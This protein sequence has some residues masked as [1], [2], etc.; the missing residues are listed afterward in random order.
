MSSVK[1]DSGGRRKKEVTAQLTS[2]LSHVQYYID[3]CRQLPNSN[4]KFHTL[5]ALVL[6]KE[7]TT[8]AQ[9]VE[10]AVC[11]HL[12]ETDRI[13]LERFVQKMNGD[14]EW[15]RNVVHLQKLVLETVR[16]KLDLAARDAEPSC[17]PS[18][19]DDLSKLQQGEGALLPD[20]AQ[21]AA[22][23]SVEADTAAPV[24]PAM[25]TILQRGV[26]ADSSMKL[27]PNTSG[28]AA[29]QTRLNLGGQQN[30]LN[31]EINLA[32]ALQQPGALPAQ[33]KDFSSAA[34]GEN[35]S[36][37]A[38]L[39]PAWLGGGGQNEKEN[40][41]SELSSVAPN[42]G[43]SQQILQRMQQEAAASQ[44]P[45]VN[46]GMPAPPGHL[47]PPNLFMSM[48]AAQQQQMK[49]QQGSSAASEVASAVGGAASAV[50]AMTA[51]SFVRGPAP[52]RFPK[53]VPDG[54]FT[55]EQQGEQDQN[56]AG[57]EQFEVPPTVPVMNAGIL[58]NGVAATEDASGVVPPT[59]FLNQSPQKH[60]T[61]GDQTFLS[62]T[63]SKQPLLPPLDPNAFS[64]LQEPK[65]ESAQSMEDMMASVMTKM[66]QPFEFKARSELTVKPLNP[67]EPMKIKAKPM[68]KSDGLQQ[69]MLESIKRFNSV[70]SQLPPRQYVT[71]D[72]QP[73]KF[74]NVDPLQKNFAPLSVGQVGV[75]FGGTG[76]ASGSSQVSR[77]GTNAMPGPL[78]GRSTEVPVW[79]NGQPVPVAQVP[80]S[81]DLLEKVARVEPNVEYYSTT[82]GRWIPAVCLGENTDGTLRLDVKM[83]A[84]P[85][86][87][88][89][90][91]QENSG[92]E[93]DCAVP[94]GPSFAAVP[95]LNQPARGQTHGSTSAPGTQ[96]VLTQP[97]LAAYSASILNCGHAGGLGG[98]PSSVVDEHQMNMRTGPAYIPLMAPPSQ[99]AAPGHD[100]RR[101]H[102]GQGI[103]DIGAPLLGG[104][105][106]CDRAEEPAPRGVR[107]NQKTSVYSAGV[108]DSC[109]SL[110][111]EMSA[112]EEAQGINMENFPEGDP[113]H[114][115]LDTETKQILEMHKLG[116]RYRAFSERISMTLNNSTLSAE[117]QQRGSSRKSMDPSQNESTGGNVRPVNCP[118]FMET[119][120]ELHGMLVRLLED[121]TLS[122]QKEAARISEKIE[123]QKRLISE[124]TSRAN[125]ERE[126]SAASSSRYAGSAAG[127]YSRNM[128]ERATPAGGP[129][130]ASGGS[131]SPL[132]VRSAP[133]RGRPGADTSMLS[134]REDEGH[135]QY[136]SEQ[137]EPPLAAAGH[138][139]SYEDSNHPINYSD[140]GASS[141]LSNN[142]NYYQYNRKNEE[143]GTSSR[144]ARS[145]PRVGRGR[146]DES[147]S[148]INL[149][150]DD[151][152]LHHQNH[153]SYDDEPYVS[154]EKPPVSKNFYRNG[155]MYK[156]TYTS[157]SSGAANYAGGG[158]AAASSNYPG[159]GGTSSGA[160]QLPPA[161]SG[162]GARAMSTRPGQ[163]R[164]IFSGRVADNAW[165]RRRRDDE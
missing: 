68:V 84:P 159:D 73:L 147:D 88:R 129:S 45:L 94:T 144:S 13:E 146:N 164:R 82:H 156:S 99:E 107:F 12:F 16:E 126:L 62:G 53:V 81:N 109:V 123:Q 151:Q 77:M 124:R 142:Q 118:K 161:G 28:V 98:Q 58:Q 47:Q 150:G 57:Q 132:P 93:D 27:Q 95:Q 120:D 10:S 63:A 51:T 125:V 131:G 36:F 40:A 127:Q 137:E 70:A 78:G 5:A 8:K 80:A 86:R 100:S 2:Y 152:I 149:E 33:N 60:Q 145:P 91:G 24:A 43:L 61:A 143:D 140:G 108:R 153:G 64:F 79:Q 56:A 154:P 114:E 148:N 32:A 103:P 130:G 111:A 105:E 104:G 138:Q 106:G 163:P 102:I 35:G 6:L 87:V 136:Y 11:H 38:G 17:Y 116:E 112:R 69:K 20:V 23:S 158:A 139:S 157:S 1:E 48:V 97:H 72:A 29:M 117:D 3:F 59:A 76:A 19:T 22:Q 37:L 128:E 66:S 31:G 15:E 67:V 71:M 44:P 160:E 54:D 55:E 83:C 18:S 34:V 46:T 30:L 141:V 115:L 50:S 75:A 9:E 14:E 85:E 74:L 52:D 90:R 4:K 21:N 121:P 25:A 42:A 101:S 162:G 92:K 165:M 39:L 135:S 89:L 110:P 155:R 65:Q 7:M 41:A 49:I 113:E 26:D 96:P 119:I 133:P 122:D 134:E